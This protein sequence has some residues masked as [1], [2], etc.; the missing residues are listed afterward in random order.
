MPEEYHNLYPGINQNLAFEIVAGYSTRG[1]IHVGGIRYL[2]IT[3][4]IPT[5][6]II[7]STYIT[8]WDKDV[9]NSQQFIVK[10][11]FSFPSFMIT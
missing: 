2:F 9:L 4:Q 1:S 3:Q 5:S 7:S 10:E 6:K 11:I 8:L